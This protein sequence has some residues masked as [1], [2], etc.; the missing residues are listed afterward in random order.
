M[1]SLSSSSGASRAR[2][3]ALATPILAI[4][5]LAVSGARPAAAAT[6]L[7]RST[8]FVLQP[9]GSVAEHVQ[10]AVRL[11]SAQ[12]LADWSPYPI[13]L[14]DNRK[15]VDLKASATQPDGK[16][17]KVG[18]KGLDTA[19]VADSFE[20]H[21]SAKLRTVEIPAVPPGSV[22]HLDYQIEEKPYFPARSVD[23]GPRSDRIERLRVEVRGAAGSPPGWRWRIDGSRDGLHVEESAGGIVVTASELPAVK[24]PEHAPER[25]GPVLRYG[26]GPAGSWSE[27]GRWYQGLVRELPRGSAAIRQKAEEIASKVG[28]G[29]RAKIEALAAFARKDVRYVAV[30][31]GIGGYRPA[32]PQ[33]VLTRRW[34]DCKD[35]SL[36]LVDLLNAA[37]I[38]A[39]PVLIRLAP[40]GRVDPEFPAVDGFNHVIVA[41]PTAGLPVTPD[42]PVAAGFLFIDATETLGS[43][44]WLPPSVQDQEALVLR[45]EQS[46]LVHTPVR[47]AAES[48]LL[49]VTLA[50]TASGNAVGQ[51]RLTLGGEVGAAWVNRLATRRPDENEAAAR[52]LLAAALPGATL[53][54]V[55]LAPSREGVP[56]LRVAARVEIPGLLPG[57]GP[58]WNLQPAMLHGLPSPGLLE[59]RTLPM[60]LTPEVTR[61]V[62]KVQLPDGACP[63]AQ[64][65]ANAE[66]D[67]GSFRQKVALEGSLLTI[68]RR[69]EL[70]QRWIEPARFAA[71]KELALAERKAE[72]RLVRLACDGGR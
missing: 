61:S 24:P 5:A 42:D 62:W 57:G 34:G 27:I 45:G 14:D 9:D 17:V 26:W 35:K 15:L 43:A 13:Y 25:L 21:S 4:V 22:F 19:E 29:P 10:L 20:L 32:A 55:S 68:E 63:P 12:D 47:P 18:R 70:T 60:V 7:D 59:G 65:D 40:Q 69:A 67:L 28:G 46:L 56:S 72:K 1:P 66:N 31:V 2:R 37:G 41:V 3:A 30:E 51:V 44:Y 54:T 39:Y 53:S 52:A 71:L 64:Q 8:T 6:I 11:E 49:E 36:L 23:L 48:R 58:A 33:D 50:A 38:E 16:V